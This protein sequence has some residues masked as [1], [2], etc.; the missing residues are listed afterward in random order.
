MMQALTL[1]EI[2]QVNGGNMVSDFATYG[3][4]VGVGF[5]VG[6]AI[7]SAAPIGGLMVIGIGLEIALGAGI[8][9]GIGYSFE[10]LF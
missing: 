9:A 10:Q 7:V 6:T 2:E 8:G 3:A 5:A 1:R 4:M